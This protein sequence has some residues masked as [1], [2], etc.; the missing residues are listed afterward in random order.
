MDYGI[1]VQDSSHD[2]LAQR[3]RDTRV[4]LENVMKM[5]NK[6]NQMKKSNENK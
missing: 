1:L 5:K 6:K 3:G 4:R 2:R